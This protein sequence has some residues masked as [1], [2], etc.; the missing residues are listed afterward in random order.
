[1]VAS[2]ASCPCDGPSKWCGLV[3]GVEAAI[4]TPFCPLAPN[5][6]HAAIHLS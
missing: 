5:R 1:M 6:I 2:A 4:G 3:W